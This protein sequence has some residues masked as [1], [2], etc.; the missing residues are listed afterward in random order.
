MSQLDL[1]SEPARPVKELHYEK[2]PL[3][4]AGYRGEIRYCHAW[5]VDE[6]FRSSYGHGL[7]HLVIASDKP[8]LGITGTGYMSRFDR[9]DNIGDPVQYVTDWIDAAAAAQKPAKRKKKQ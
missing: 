2:F 8:I 4:H 1:F 3:D 6:I 9:P 5:F 7:S